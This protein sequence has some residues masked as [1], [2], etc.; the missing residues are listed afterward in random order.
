M[1]VLSKLRGIITY[2]YCV[3]NYY[4]DRLLGYS[5]QNL[6]QYE[7]A[8]EYYIEAKSKGV[9][10]EYTFPSNVAFCYFELSEYAKALEHTHKAAK[11]EPGDSWVNERLDWSKKYV[12]L[13]LP[14]L[15]ETCLYAE[16]YA[17]TKVALEAWPNDSEFLAYSGVLEIVFKH[18][19]KT[20][21]NILI[22]PSN[23]IM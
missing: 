2:P 6:G 16:A 9:A 4:S 8:L 19:H 5:Y 3:F 13:N 11:L 22:K 14:G 18:N 20:G 12:S 15:I 17:L 7:K 10:Q 23:L 1:Y 21:K